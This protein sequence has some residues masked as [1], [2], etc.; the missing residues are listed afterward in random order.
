MLGIGTMAL[1]VVLAKPARAGG[2]VVEVTL[3]R[4]VAGLSVQLLWVGVA[5]GRRADLRVFR[6]TRVWRTLIP[7]SI[8]GTYIAMLFWMGGFKWAP[9][10]VASV[11]NQLSSVFTLFFAWLLLRERMSLRKAVGAGVA[12]LGAVLVLV[13][14]TPP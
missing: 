14:H 10:T 11:L 12:I 13:T 3:V 6:N 4:L 2:H 9:V 8:L 1:G 7:A 5:P